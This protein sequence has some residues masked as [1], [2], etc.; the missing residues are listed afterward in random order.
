MEITTDLHPKGSQQVDD[1]GHEV[2]MQIRP[3]PEFQ[4]THSKYFKLLDFKTQH[5]TLHGAYII[6]T[7][8]MFALA[9]IL[10]GVFWLLFVVCFLKSY[11]R[12][13]EEEDENYCIDDEGLILKA[14][15]VSLHDEVKMQEYYDP[16]VNKNEYLVSQFAKHLI[17]NVDD[18]V[19]REMPIVLAKLPVLDDLD[20]G[21]VTPVGFGIQNTIR[22]MPRLGRYVV[23]VNLLKRLVNAMMIDEAESR[24]IE[25]WIKKAYSMIP[26]CPLSELR[27]HVLLAAKLYSEQRNITYHFQKGPYSQFTP[28]SLSQEYVPCY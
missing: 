24:S 4:I 28:Q 6:L 5:L 18:D 26:A 14:K 25:F 23:N 16:F 2:L 10:H 11:T 21:R 27:Q 20:I 19:M 12:V 22:V 13:S 9:I 1:I 17:Q 7:I 15:L 8:L 3:R